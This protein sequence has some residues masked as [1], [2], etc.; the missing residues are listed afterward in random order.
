MTFFRAIEPEFNR[1]VLGNAP[2]QQ[3]AT[4][5]DWTEGPVWFGD[6]NCLL[7]SD[8]PN[9]RIVRWMPEV[10]ISTYRS[11][12]NYANGHT[13]DREGRLISCEHGERRVTRTEHDGSVTVLADSFNGKRLNSPNDVVVKSDGS[14]WFTDPHYGIM[15]NYE[16]FAGEQELPCHVYRIDPATGALD[17]MLTDF[18]CPNGLAFSPDEKRLYVAETGTM[19]NADA[20]RHIRAFDVGE[21]GKLHGGDVFHVVNPGFADGIRVDT[22]GNIWS[23]AGDGV[24]CLNSDGVLL[25]KILIPETVSNLCFGGRAKHRLFI[26]A[27]T[28]I[29]SIF[30]NREGMQRP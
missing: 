16:G 20:E 30:L 10:G 1:F 8:I 27:T 22:D 11:P 17:S 4:G 7:F 24:H 3:L 13:R 5:F 9:D 29:Y 19:F 18:E 15:T 14:I 25:G 2:V 6:A 23:S 26:T 21:D 12:S 28:S